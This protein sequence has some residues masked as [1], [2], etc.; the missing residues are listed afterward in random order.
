MLGY[1]LL[2]HFMVKIQAELV[3]GEIPAKSCVQGE[4]F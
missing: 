2:G 4:S 1:F 3:S